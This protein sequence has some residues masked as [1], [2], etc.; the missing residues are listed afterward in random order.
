MS[1]EVVYNL[2]IRGTVFKTIGFCSVRTVDQERVATVWMCNH[3][4]V[5]WWWII[6]KSRAVPLQWLPECQLTH[7][8]CPAGILMDWLEPHT[9]VSWF[10]PGLEGNKQGS[11]K[12]E[13]ERGKST[14]SFNNSDVP[15]PVLSS[16]DIADSK[17]TPFLLCRICIQV[18]VWES[19]CLQE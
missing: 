6:E 17:K 5:F 19:L 18:E 2:I 15:G 12:E 4:G 8:S 11:Y 10:S 16:E 13:G 3:I 7:P 9:S 14:H 1:G